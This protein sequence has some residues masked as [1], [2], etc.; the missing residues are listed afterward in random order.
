MEAWID[1]DDEAPRLMRTKAY[2]S[3]TRHLLARDIHPGQFLSQRELVTLTGLPLGVI[4]ELIPRLEAEG[5]IKTVPQ[6][7]L[8][9]T[10]LD[11]DLVREVFQFRLFI[12]REAIALFCQSASEAQLATLRKE[13]EDMLAR[14][15]H[16]GESPALEAQAKTIDCNLHNTIVASLNNKIIWRSYNTN[17]IKMWLINQKLVRIT[18]RIAL[19]MQEHLDII[20][21]IESRHAQTAVEAMTNHINRS[22]A[23]ALQI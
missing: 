1:I 21:A 13:H 5:L 4:R 6:R 8:Q 2:Q 16:E 12:E 7:G 11:L 3:F 20:K 10:H 9:I 14:I 23:I 17:A 22:R 18:G 15:N 19:T